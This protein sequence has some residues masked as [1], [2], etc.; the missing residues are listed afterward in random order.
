MSLNDPAV[1]RLLN[2]EMK[3]GSDWIVK[4]TK[5]IYDDRGHLISVFGQRRPNAG[6]DDKPFVNLH[7]AMVFHGN[8]C[9]PGMPDNTPPRHPRSLIAVRLYL[10]RGIARRTSA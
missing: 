10:G 3:E 7:S 8:K 1:G 6:P 4:I 2:L 5:L 9:K